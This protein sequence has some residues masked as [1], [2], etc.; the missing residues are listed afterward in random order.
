MDLL[1]L[2]RWVTASH[3]VGGI[4]VFM[5]PVIQ[6]LGRLDCLLWADDLRILALPEEALGTIEESVRLTDHGTQSYLWVLGAYEFARTFHQRLRE[7]NHPF[8]RDVQ[9]FK[10]TINRIR[11]PLA[12]MEAAARS[13]DDSHIAYPCLSRAHGMAWQLTEVDFV[14]RGALGD[15]LLTCLERYAEHCRAHVAS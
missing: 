2:Q 15:E 9:L 13:P 11:I 14:A 8:E 12:K 7:A 6:G 5:M 4:E 10:Q 3:S 1:R